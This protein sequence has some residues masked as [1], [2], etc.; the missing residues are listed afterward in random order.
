V[1]RDSLVSRAPKIVRNSEILNSRVIKVY[2]VNVKLLTIVVKK[3]S[4]VLVK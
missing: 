2:I 3:F 1:G 4:Q